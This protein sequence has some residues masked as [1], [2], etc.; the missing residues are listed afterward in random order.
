MG[1]EVHPATP[2]EARRLGI[3]MVHQHF[4]AVPA[5]S[6]QEN[7]ALAAG[8]APAPQLLGRR[9]ESLMQRVGMS[10]DPA[11]RSDTLTVAQRQALE[12]LMALA[13]EARILLLD[14]PTASLAER[15]AER[16]LQVVRQFAQRG[17]GAVL[18]THKLE[19]ALRYAD[20]I[21]VLRRGSVTLSGAAQEQDT[22]GLARAMLGEAPSSGGFRRQ[23]V[24]GGIVASARSLVV[25][26]V[27]GGSGL[28]GVDLELRS[29][30]VVGVAAVEGNGERELL[31]AM[32]GLVAPSGGIVEVTGLRCLIPED[33]T[34]EALLPQF[35]LTENRALAS[36]AGPGWIDWTAEGAATSHLIESGGVTASGPG[37]K[38]AE[39]SGGNQ[40][41]FV[42]ARQL[43]AEPRLIVAENPS[44]GLDFKATADVFERL[45]SAA[46]AGAAVLFHSVDLDEVLTMAD[47]VVVLHRGK[48]IVPPHGA[49]RA[50]IGRLM[51]TG[52]SQA[53]E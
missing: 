16:V 3:G 44:R 20:H 23:A 11:A 41:R 26:A 43:E 38:A 35:T 25:E 52:E 40:Q 19:E 48:L 45:R 53:G 7:I 4:S 36:G 1:R 33:R 46:Q 21:T 22:S 39:L 18:I 24:V 30:E 27:S 13:G 47:R 32:A 2:R 17:G 49:D 6:V 37:A 8:W 9:V 42:I 50:V 14:E 28:S 10:L 15:D 5:F 34:T 31:R 51:L 12:I 29:R